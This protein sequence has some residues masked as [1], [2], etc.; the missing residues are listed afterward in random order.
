M[1]ELRVERLEGPDEGLVLL[2][3]D[4]PASKNAL[5]RQLLGELE[6]AFASLAADTACRVVV[7]HSLVDGVFCAGADLK[8]RAGMSPEEAE[9]FVKRLRAAFTA[10][11][12]LPMP[13]IAGI[14]GAALGGGL[15]LALACDLRVAGAGAAL[16]LPETS[17]AIIPGAGGTQRLPR[18]I[19]RSRAKEL[20]F[21][22]RR[23]SPAE[24]LE[25]GLVDRAVD[26]GGALAGALDLARGILP[27]GPVALRAAKEAID[28]GLDRDRDG[29][30][31]VEEA[32]Y[33]RVL[34]TEDRLEGLAAFR[35]KRK[36]VY[37][38]R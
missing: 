13:V 4:R 6:A 9:A 27:N 14:D 32:C 20:I 31:A 28:A 16:G 5:G 8:E 21:T 26:A 37:R 25:L 1:A 3:L 30:L 34:P 7:L 17:L 19:G 33:A 22:A 36:P 23:L 38:G 29:G 15:E 24:A 35:E 2:G 11:E 12:R 18:I 10:L